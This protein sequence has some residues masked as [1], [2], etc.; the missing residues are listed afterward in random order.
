[1]KLFKQIARGKGLILTISLF[2]VVI[3]VTYTISGAVSNPSINGKSSFS[4]SEEPK[5]KLPPE[6]TID[7]V[8]FEG[9][10][11]FQV[12][13]DSQQFTGPVESCTW[14]FGDGE[15]FQGPVASHTFTSAGNYSVTL[16]AKEKTGKEHQKKISVLVLPKE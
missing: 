3:M 10:A 4:G 12:T 9:K 14:N 8:D 7:D 5:L 13:F 6:L 16:T 1:M 15:T 2:C 11:P